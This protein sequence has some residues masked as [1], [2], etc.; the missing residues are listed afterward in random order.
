MIFI[1]T[2]V[3]TRRIR[4][5]MPDEAYAALQHFLLLRPDAGAVIPQSGGLRKLRWRLPDGGKRGG[6]RLIYYFDPPYDTIYLLLIYQKNQ[7]EDLSPD[8]LR[9]L[10][11]LM[12]EWLHERE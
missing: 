3:F 12:K 4:E 8:Q 7:Q 1:E 10:R 9:I 6:L 11:Q 2:P 5:L